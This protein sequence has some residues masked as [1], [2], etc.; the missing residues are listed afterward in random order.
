MY[1]Q[2]DGNWKHL[3]KI[4]IVRLNLLYD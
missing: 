1:I 4:S 3:S 2:D